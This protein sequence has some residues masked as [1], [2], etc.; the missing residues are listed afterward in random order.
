[1]RPR[2]QQCPKSAIGA[3]EDMYSQGVQNCRKI[4]RFSLHANAKLIHPIQGEW[5]LTLQCDIYTRFAATQFQR[6]WVQEQK[7]SKSF[8]TSWSFKGCFQQPTIHQRIFCNI[9][10]FIKKLGVAGGN[11]LLVL[12]RIFPSRGEFLKN[13]KVGV[14]ELG[15]I[16]KSCYR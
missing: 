15:F 14:T 5:I 2:P 6:A 1:M 9:L 7:L 12:S 10:C 13:G 16:F 8:T 11:P 4:S 3:S